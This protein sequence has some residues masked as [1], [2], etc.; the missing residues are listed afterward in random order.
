MPPRY[1]S[2]TVLFQPGWT[3]RRRLPPTIDPAT[4]NTRPGGV[5]D[6]PGRGLVQEALWTG[7][8]EVTPTTVSDERVIMWAPELVNI[9]D[10]DIQANDEFIGPRG[11]V[12]QAVSDGHPRGIPG[13]PHEYVALRARRAREKEK[14]GNHP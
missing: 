5:E 12:W 14:K 3:Y 6:Q 9:M 4:G 1:A 8:K 10:L 13:R 2:A 7:N 11:E